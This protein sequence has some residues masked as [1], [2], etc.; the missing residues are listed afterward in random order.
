MMDRY[1][2]V[3][4][5]VSGHLSSGDCAAAA[6]R[7]AAANLIFRI[8]Y[9]NV[10][11][12]QSNGGTVSC[13]VS[14]VVENCNAI[15]S[16]YVAVMEGGTPPDIREKCNIH[17]CVSRISDVR[18]IRENAFIDIRYGNLFL[19]GG[20]G[21]GT[22]ASDMP[23][24]RKGEA[25]IEKDA[26]TLIFDAVSD[27]C[28][29]SDGAQLLLVTVSC[30]EG[31]MIA[32]KHSMGQNVFSGGVTIMG[33]S[34][35][36]LP[37]HM[38]DISDS[39]DAQIRFQTAQG[40]KSILVSPGNYCAKKIYES[41]HV[42]LKTSIFC[43]NFPGQA[44]DTAVEEKVENLLLVGNAGKLVKLAAG[45]MN[46]NSTAADAR[47]EIFAA[48]ISM[49]GGTAAQ[50]KT[51]MGCVTV[52]E[53]L[54]LLGAWGLRERVMQSIMGQ[55][56]RSVMGRCRGKLKFGVALFSEEFGLLGVTSE[57]KNVLIK[58]SQEQYALSLR[59]K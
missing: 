56:E 24:I 59:M 21:I 15:Q 53:M 47:K 30:P 18:T 36:L 50:A 17:V 20:E 16:E 14:Q 45:I 26:R 13:P 25:L 46:T 54:A 27:V 44:I 23:G 8:K 58:V 32:A 43:Y 37:V 38:R 1:G 9:E 55:I 41:L 52:D 35:S 6:A 40:V 57:T 49:V 7:A 42:D 12:A 48:H 11:I 29:M 31:M 51:I 39:I 28:E 2:T 4:G 34:G 10:S 33:S 5:H 3:L 19:Q 22:A